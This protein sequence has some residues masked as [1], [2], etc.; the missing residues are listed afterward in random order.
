MPAVGLLLGW[1]QED[2]ASV[3]Y[4]F[5][6]KDHGGGAILISEN[7]IDK[8]GVSRLSIVPRMFF[9]A[10]FPAVRMGFASDKVLNT[11]L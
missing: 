2:P 1:H 8:P 10:H 11:N 4:S 6:F 9:V 3:L 7:K 5:A